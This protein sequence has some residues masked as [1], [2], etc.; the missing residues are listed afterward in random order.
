M[1]IKKVI[2]HALPN[3]RKIGVCFFFQLILIKN[4]YWDMD[5][6]VQ[7]REYHVD[8]K[9]R[10]KT[11]AEYTKISIMLNISMKYTSVFKV[12]LEDRF[13]YR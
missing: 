7:K 10:H 12:V 2:I 6:G 9:N 13:I 1:K 3:L 5:E 4:F 11:C 8:L